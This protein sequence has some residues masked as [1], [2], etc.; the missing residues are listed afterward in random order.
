[1]NRDREVWE[2]E[3]AIFNWYY[4]G[5][6]AALKPVFH[7]LVNGL[8]HDMQ[9]RIPLEPSAE[10][11]RGMGEPVSWDEAAA[12]QVQHIAADEE[13][14]FLI[15]LFTSQEE[16]DKGGASS[17][18]QQPLKALF[19]AVDRWPDCVGYSINPWGQKLVLQKPVIQMLLG[20]QPKSHITVGKGSVVGMHVDAIV[21][22]A[23]T[24]LLGGGGVDGAIHRAAGPGLLEECRT[25]HGC[26]TG[27]AKITGAYKI[28]NAT[29]IIHTVGPV[30]GGKAED[31]ALLAACYTNSLD[32]A[33]KYGC[34]SIA[35]PGI[36]T[37]VYGYPLN[38]AAKVSFR[39]V[40]Q[41]I[42]AHPDT[43]MDVYFCC[44]KD[45][46]VEAYTAWTKEKGR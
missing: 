38:E 37:G 25:L 5:D 10:L 6:E 17:F 36:S 11:P 22:A 4:G 18:V 39:A 20:Y 28:E 35:F 23:N 15:P 7:A 31:A 8:H 46:E 3:R 40:T 21:N 19:E 14:H 27:E 13:G 42:Q 45:A 34:S 32:L 12:I 16:M 33:L 30:Y 1:M 2:L 26:H 41:W 43:V 24:S 44:F 9:V 29:Y